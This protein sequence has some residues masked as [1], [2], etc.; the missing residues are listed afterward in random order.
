MRTWWATAL[1]LL[2]VALGSGAAGASPPDRASEL[3]ARSALPHRIAG[4][5]RLV[6]VTEPFATSTGG[7]RVVALDRFTGREVASL[8]APPGG[9]KLPFT[10]RVPG[11]GHLVVLDNAGF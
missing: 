3:A 2:L 11:P 7:G 9:F 8:P 5:R 6:F 1:C 4:D 10:L